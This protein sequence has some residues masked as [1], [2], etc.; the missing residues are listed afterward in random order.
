MS[1]WNVSQWFSFFASAAL[2][3]TVVLGA[4]WLAAWALR[5]RSA[6]LRHLVWTAAAAAVLALPFLSASLPALRVPASGALLPFDPAVVFQVT[7]SAAVEPP[8]S[9]LPLSATARRATNAPR[10]SDWRIW[11]MALWAAGAAAAFARMFA[12][13][14]AMWRIRRAAR[15]FPDDGLANALAQSLGIPG[16]V[17]VLEGR[18]GSMPMTFG[19]LRPAVFMPPEAAAWSEERRHV[20]LLH[21]LAHVRRG[22]AATHL[23]ARTALS[24]NCWNPLAWSAWREFLKERERATDDLVLNAGARAPDYAGHL[25]EVARTLQSA[26]ATAWAAV[27]MARRSQLE[28]RLLAILDSGVKRHVPG[29]MATLAATLLA[30]AAVAPFAAMRAQTPAQQTAPPKADDTVRFRAVTSGAAVAQQ[31][32]AP[33]ADDAAGLVKLGDQARRQG[34]LDEAIGYY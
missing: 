7:G 18:P 34:H 26:P 29:R 12:A 17:C 23:L 9:A 2:K 10:Y 27:A 28:G 3:S 31:T 19:L 1:I 32:T 30:I 22:D 14:I 24:L 15:P 13:F 25:L 33:S 5:G 20:V 6:A 16:P 11:L 21:E 8:S 4:A